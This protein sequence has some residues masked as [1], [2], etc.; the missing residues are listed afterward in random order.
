MISDWVRVAGVS[1][2]KP[3][4][5]IQV[6]VDEEPVALANVDGELLAV[7]DICSHEYFLLS[8]G[9]VEEDQ[10]ECSKHGSLFSLRTGE[11]INLPAIHPVPVYEVKV[12]GDDVL[13]KGPFLK[14]EIQGESS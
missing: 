14:S 4:A 1:D 6:Q 9:W 7:G 10:I 12:E 3:G 11:A 5:V 2:V 8:D 13:L